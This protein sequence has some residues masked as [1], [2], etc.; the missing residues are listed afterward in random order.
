LL[1]GANN[2]GGP[3]FTYD[4]ATDSF[5]DQTSVGVELTNNLASVSRDGS[6]IAIQN[7]TILGG[8]VS[9]VDRDLH[10][11]A[12]LVDADGGVAFDPAR[13]VLYTASS[14]TDQITAYDTAT[15]AVKYRLPVGEHV[16]A[17]SAF[18]NGVMRVSDDGTELFLSTPSGVRM[19][20]LPPSTGL[21]ARLEVGGF[22]SFVAAGTIGAFTVTA[23]DPAGDVAAGFAGTVH[24]S[25]TDPQALLQQDYTFTP[26]DQGVHT[27][28]AALLSDGAFAITAADA[29][30]GLSG[31]QA[32]IRVHTGPTSL[33]PIADRRNFVYDRGRGLLY[34]TTDA[35]TVERY[36]LATQSLLPPFR[37]GDS[38]TGA[39]I[40]PDGS[41]LFVCDSRGGL[42][43]GFFRKVNL[44]D[45]TVT[46]LTYDVGRDEWGS[47]DVAIASNGTGLFT[48]TVKM[49]AFPWLRQFD[50]ATGAFTSRMEVS[51]RDYLHHGADRS[52]IFGTESSNGLGTIFTYDPAT[53][54]FHSADTYVPLDF[55]RAA[56]NR[57]GSLIALQF[58]NNSVAILDRN[59]NT[60]RLLP[61]LGGSVAFDPLRDLLYAG[62]GAQVIA[63]DTTT[64]AE[65]FRIDVG[66]G[67][68]A[69]P[70]GNGGLGVSD[71]G[72]LLFVST[73][74]G[75][76]VLPI[77]AFPAP[78]S[79]ADPALVSASLGASASPARGSY[80]DGSVGPVIPM[81]EPARPAARMAD[82]MSGAAA[83]RPGTGG[84]LTPQAHPV[85]TH[86]ETGLVNND[87]PLA[88]EG[89]LPAPDPLSDGR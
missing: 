52:L 18:G 79:A 67:F 2:S 11:V 34:I 55:Y 40:T 7:G 53:D 26:A 76:R 74:S 29:A 16:Q 9:V 47:W 73:D 36:D 23:R 63:Y 68:G 81:P 20:D 72:S 13:D 12:N 33:V 69:A 80:T 41:A 14:H 59:L 21:A 62:A 56:V 65:Q 85:R 58:L 8:G 3:L 60:L 39:D 84:Y 32:G 48:A 10:A 42:T 1:T 31:S 24:L 5:S 27:F 49:S 86:G 46:N 15:W 25:S 50:L 66:E 77:P 28:H 64:W 54:S 35:G 22:P 37:V 88:R 43:Q 57:D 6:L 83:F 17:A 75:V 44:T 78:A 89:L 45:G 51:A 87:L 38:L 61:N 82:G 71:D 4:A 70:F 19:I 30:D